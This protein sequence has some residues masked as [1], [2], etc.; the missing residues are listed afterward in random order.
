MEQRLKTYALMQ[1]YYDYFNAA[2]TDG[3]LTLLS[4]DVIHEI[5]QGEA[6]QGMA[7]FRDF[8]TRMNRCYRE[9]VSDLQ[10]FVNEDGTRAAAEFVVDG[11]YV[12]TDEGLP[13][14]TG[15]AYQ[16]PAGAFFS[17]SDGKIRRVTMYYNLQQWLNQVHA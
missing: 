4:D 13:P 8:F 7:A 2:N 10:L 9:Q 1:Q 16:L 6:E 5:N 11:E 17:L 14:A 12:A 15:Q 3:M